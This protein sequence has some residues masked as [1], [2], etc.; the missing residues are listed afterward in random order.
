MNRRTWGGV[1][2]AGVMTAAGIVT[3][4]LPVKG[5]SSRIESTS[6]PKNS[7]RIAFVS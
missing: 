6:S 3:P 2:C 1:V 7:T 5:S 4:H